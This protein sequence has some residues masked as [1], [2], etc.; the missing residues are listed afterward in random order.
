M[1]RTE[2][3]AILNDFQGTRLQ[4][5]AQRL[6]LT[7]VLRGLPQYLQANAGVNIKSFTCPLHEGTHG[8]VEV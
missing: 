8:G 3:I 5:S 1:I 2:N 6:A 7:E 4:I